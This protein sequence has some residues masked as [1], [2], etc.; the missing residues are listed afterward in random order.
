MAR[1]FG[2]GGSGCDRAAPAA[3]GKTV[4]G[5]IATWLP[6]ALV[7]ARVVGAGLMVIVPA[8]SLGLAA[9]VVGDVR[10]K[11]G[12]PGLAGTVE[13]MGGGGGSFWS[14]AIDGAEL[15]AVEGGN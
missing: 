13:P 6:P 15:S 1:G 8:G 4:P 2:M 3:P 11:V 7:C 10:G 14:E 12:K 9:D 5:S